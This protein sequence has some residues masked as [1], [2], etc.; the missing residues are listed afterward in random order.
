MFGFILGT[1]IL[2]SGLI[3]GVWARKSYPILIGVGCAMLFT[4]L[5]CL[6]SVPTG[7]TG[8]VTTFGKV[9]NYTL[10]AG[11]HLKAPWHSVVTMDN[12]VQKSTIQMSCFSSDIQETTMSYTINYQI[13]KANAQ[14]IYATLGKDYYSTI[15]EPS[16]FE[17][18]KVA[19]AKYTAEQLVQNRST[20]ATDIE[21]LLSESLARY[22]IKVASTA[23]EDMDFTDAFT[24]AV[25]AKQVAEQKK[26]QAEIEQ[27]QDLAKAENDKKIA[28]TNARANAEVAKI[29]AEADMEVAKIGADSAEYQGKKE[30]SIA[31]QRLASIN[32]WTV[33][34]DE[35]TELN[36]LYKA[37]G[38]KVTDAE[39]KIGAENLIDYY[40]IQ[41]WNGEMP[42]TVL[43]DSDNVLLGI[44]K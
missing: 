5:G 44:S 12:R 37:D 8:I 25:E 32:G 31:L 3:L 34:Y 15:V 33:V 9:E 16:V 27:A 11:F 13:D 23:I 29:Q 4:L 30:A 20:L 10:E 2:V 36:I 28:E 39:L 26:K 24:N 35:E 6:A 43:G 21:R 42:D 18:V 41:Q 38:K 1:S 14:E 19:T 40:H 17:A 22:N 7:N